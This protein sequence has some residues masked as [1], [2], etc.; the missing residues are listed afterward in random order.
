LYIVPAAYLWYH[1]RGESETMAGAVRV[2]R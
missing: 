2:E 1:G